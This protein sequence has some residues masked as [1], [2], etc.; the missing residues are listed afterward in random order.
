MWAVIG[1]PVIRYSPIQAP[2]RSRS[3]VFV[4]RYSHACSRPPSRFL[5]SAF[6]PP[7][8]TLRVAG[9]AHGDPLRRVHEVGRRFCAGLLSPSSSQVPTSTKPS[10]SLLSRIA[11]IVWD[12]VPLRQSQQF[13][14]AT[15]LR[16]GRPLLSRNSQPPS[17]SHVLIFFLSTSMRRGP[18]SAAGE[19]AADLAGDRC[20]RFQGPFPFAVYFET[21][22]VN[23]HSVQ[24]N[25][26]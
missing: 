9:G 15:V 24:P 7:P 10:R 3:G 4:I 16:D 23:S 19:E 25:T 11:Q 18:T 1:F 14:A 21:H 13:S 6:I 26:T 12:L 2:L 17:P 20:H 22:C 8:R 5:S